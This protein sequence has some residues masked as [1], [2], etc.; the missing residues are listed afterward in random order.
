[1][2]I[3]S[4]YIRDRA[5]FVAGRHA[6]FRR[7]GDPTVE[8][9]IQDAENFLVSLPDTVPMPLIS[10]GTTSNLGNVLVLTWLVQVGDAIEAITVTFEGHG[11]SSAQWPDRAG[12]L[13]QIDELPSDDLQAIDVPGLLAIYRV[14]PR[15]N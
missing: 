4:G 5:Y 10:S 2:H 14:A 7:Q 12:N 15:S 11:R 9:A 6:Q 1:M 8:S 13:S 3:G